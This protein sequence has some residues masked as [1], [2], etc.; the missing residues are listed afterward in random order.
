MVDTNLSTISQTSSDVDITGDLTGD[1]V[2]SQKL[3]AAND[4]GQVINIVDSSSDDEDDFPSP[5]WQ[6]VSVI[7]DIERLEAET[8]KN[9]AKIDSEQHRYQLAKR[10]QKMPLNLRGVATRVDHTHDERAALLHTRHTLLHN[11]LVAA[12]I[13]HDKLIANALR[14]S[15]SGSKPERFERDDDAFPNKMESKMKTHY[16]DLHTERNTGSER[17]RGE[18]DRVHELERRRVKL[19]STVDEQEDELSETMSKLF[20]GIK[21]GKAGKRNW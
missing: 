5:D 18:L 21:I 10:R 19:Q 14:V 16:V 13:Q 20:E 15:Y 12:K 7:A 6:L 4:N 3:Q 8:A 1:E 9:Y 2:Q 17:V 11:E